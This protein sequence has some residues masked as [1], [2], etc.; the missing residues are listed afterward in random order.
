MKVINCSRHFAASEANKELLARLDPGEW[1]WIFIQEPLEGIQTPDSSQFVFS[2]HILSLP[3]LTSQFWDVT[4]PA[5]IHIIIDDEFQEYVMQPI[6]REQAKEIYDFL[7]ANRNKNVIVS[8]YAGMCRSGA[9]CQFAEKYL[10]AE[11]LEGFKQ[12]AHPNPKVYD[13]LVEVWK[14]SP[15]V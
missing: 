3:T 1:A 12:K 7:I 5:H 15:I 10:N 4:R 14:S 9:V 8:C 13:E 11:W 6:V 2:D